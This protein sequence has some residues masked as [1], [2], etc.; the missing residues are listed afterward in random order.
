ME[1]QLLK[2]DCQLFSRYFPTTLPIM[3]WYFSSE[4]PRNSTQPPAEKWSCMFEHITTI[5]RVRQICFSKNSSGCSGAACYFGFTSPSGKAGAFLSTKEK[6]KKTVDFG[7]E[8]YTQIQAKQPL[9][10]Y[11]VLASLEDIEDWV[12]V[13]VINCWVTPQ[14]LA[15]LVTLANFDSPRNDNV[16]LPFASGCQAIWTIPYK[17]SDHPYPKATVGGLDP[18]MRKYIARD[19]LIFSVPSNCFH[20]MTQN[21]SISFAQDESWLNLIDAV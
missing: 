5:D 1:A 14:I 16:Q 3:G 8:F 7:E 17:E 18:A 12:Q 21:I 11:L 6:F 15:G 2:H 10:E 9:K 4:P 19:S 20:T 13:E